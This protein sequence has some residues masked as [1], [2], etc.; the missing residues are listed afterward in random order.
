[1]TFSVGLI[2]NSWLC[3]SSW[4]KELYLGLYH[5]TLLGVC[6]SNLPTRSGKESCRLK[7]HEHTSASSLCTNSETWRVV[8][9]VLSISISWYILWMSNQMLKYLIQHIDNIGDIL[10]DISNIA[11]ITRSICPISNTINHLPI[12]SKILNLGYSNSWSL[13]ASHLQQDQVVIAKYSL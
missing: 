13:H 11:N 1:M 6:G 12:Y 7:L 3:M 10:T 2:L 4:D 9:R 8:G 5:S